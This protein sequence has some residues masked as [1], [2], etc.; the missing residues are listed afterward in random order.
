MTPLFHHSFCLQARQT[1]EVVEI[2]LKALEQ[3]GLPQL[4]ACLCIG[5]EDK[6]Q[7]VAVAQAQGVHCIVATPGTEVHT[8]SFLSNIYSSFLTDIYSFLINI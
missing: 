1:Y 5:G 4:R 3:G 7:Q 6:R 2:Y 8:Y